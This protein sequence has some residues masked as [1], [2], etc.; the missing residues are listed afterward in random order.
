MSVDAQKEKLGF[1]TEVRQ[2]LDLMIHSLYSNKEIFLRELV[3]NASDAADKLR[4]EALSDGEL[5]EGDGD[6]SIRVDYDKEAHTVTVTDNGIGMSREEVI[7]HIGTIAKSGTRQFFDSLTGDAAKDAEL[8]G[9]FGVGF[10]SSFIVADR[11]VLTT[12]RAGM[13][14]QEGVRWESSGDGEY[15]VETIDRAKRGTQ[16]VLHLREAEVEFADGFRLRS[17]LRKYSDHIS[18]PIVMR[19][20]GEDKSADETVNSATALWRRAKNE[21][22]Q[23]EYDEF[24]KHVAHDFEAPLAY[25]HSRVEGKLEYAS[26]LFIPAR[27][28]FDL[29]D[30]N[31]RRG[32]KLYVRR[33]FI[34]DDAEDL[35][36]SYLRFVRGVID[37]A[38]LPLNISR[39]TLQ[40]NKQIES[41]RA[42]S[43]KK[44]LGLLAGIAENEAEKFAMFWAEFGRVL[45]E[46]L[47][48]D[49]GNRE[50]VAKLLRFSSTHADSAVQ[51]VSLADYVGR[52]KEGQE[53]IFFITAGNF[54]TARNSPHLEVFRSKGIE[55]LLLSD[56]VDEIAVMHL[57]EFDGK[58]LQ[59]VSKG[60]L[61]LGELAG[62]EKEE[63]DEGSSESEHA[64]LI[65]R[66]KAC[67]GERVK[68]VRIT[69]RLSV[70]PACLVA[71]EDEMSAHLERLLVS[72]GQKVP[73]SKPI[74]ELNPEHVL[75]KALHKETDE[76]R[77]T[78]LSHILFDQALLSE[79][80]QLE[81][82][83]AFVR[84]LNEMLS[85]LS[86]PG[87]ARSGKGTVKPAAKTRRPAKT[88]TEKSKT[89]SVK[90]S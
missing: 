32:I 89:A 56:D 25:V 57:V 41:I 37:S 11:V 79:G 4:F 90:Q 14:R 31:T 33:I 77:F 26:L 6:L 43:V 68:D 28:P 19:E 60:S 52:M 64:A 59:S 18:L 76:Q 58:P 78:D 36:P 51:D 66:V 87:K 46:G 74:F 16:V 7:D 10:Y 30:K 54:D 9:Q 53:K 73:G 17:I 29:W 44:V 85:R 3:S 8:I 80:G 50:A 23:E 48:D 82:P 81:E 5:F 63:T 40:R 84:R 20:E 13:A 45:K 62:E 15:T 71:D 75:V 67:L 27:A 1:Q 47:I 88:K 22:E 2:L 42:G 49:P 24:Y 35:M 69:R 61:D 72:A 70:S 65:E 38:D 21:I 34:M 86:A 12:R 83:T 39:E 55:V